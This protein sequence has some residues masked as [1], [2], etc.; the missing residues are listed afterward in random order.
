MATIYY[1]KTDKGR[2]EISSRKYQLPSKLR[3]LLVMIDGKHG[4][5]ELLKRLAA[6]GLTQENLEEL[7]R[8]GFITPVKVSVPAPVELA[9]KDTP[10]VVEET[11]TET[12]E[13]SKQVTPAEKIANLRQFFTETIKGNLG[14]RGFTLQL[15]VERAETLE[16]FIGLSED[17]VEAL[18]KAKGQQIA[19]NLEA[20]L[21]DLIDDAR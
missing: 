7:L 13:T 8:L 1:D 18:Y 4:S 12:K 10:Q 15:K 20:R 11:K 19:R 21:Q 6:I 5:D 16:D 9:R 17:Y 3:P 2:E 14:L